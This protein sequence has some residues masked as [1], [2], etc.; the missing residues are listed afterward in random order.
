VNWG[1]PNNSTSSVF[2][3]GATNTLTNGQT[4]TSTG[5]DTTTTLTITAAPNLGTGQVQFSVNHQYVDDGIAPGN[6]TP[7]DTST[8]AVSVSD[9][10]SG[11]VTNTTSVTVNNS[12][13][14]INL[15]DTAPAPTAGVAFTLTGNTFTDFGL[16]DAHVLQVAW[17]AP[18]GATSSFNIP[19]TSTLIVNQVIPS[20]VP[21]D[22]SS[23][24]I[25]SVS[26]A[27]GVVGF[28]LTHTYPT[29][30]V[31]PGVAITA[32]LTDD[33]SGTGIDILP[34][35]IVAPVAVP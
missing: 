29:V 9:P 19:T 25:T 5:A 26:T 16:R 15:N 34:G 11:N 10:D 20:Q 8:I 27:T 23:M 2:S 4:F 30:V 12:V 35:V 24:K 6:G 7:A 3:L 33:D 13:P 32:T 14:Q 18:A 22:T 31:A 21:G 1:D 28:E 17:G